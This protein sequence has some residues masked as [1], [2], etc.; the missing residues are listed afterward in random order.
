MTDVPSMKAQPAS[1]S[2]AS[3]G[4]KS[5]Y[6][7]QYLSAG[8]VRTKVQP[9][10]SEP[11]CQCRPDEGVAWSGR[12]GQKKLKMPPKGSELVQNTFRLKTKGSNVEPNQPNSPNALARALKRKI[13]DFKNNS[14]RII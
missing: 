2:E 12:R 11:S 7:E 9:Q 4:R 13:T 10:R 6:S 5:D 8:I 3:S 1:F 14:T